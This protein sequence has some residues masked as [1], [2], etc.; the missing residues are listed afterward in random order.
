MSEHKIELKKFNGVVLCTMYIESKYRYE[1][2]NVVLRHLHTTSMS[3]YRK[4]IL[5][6]VDER[7]STMRIC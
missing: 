7:R 2:V 6:Y 4:G 1:A 3:L 5:V